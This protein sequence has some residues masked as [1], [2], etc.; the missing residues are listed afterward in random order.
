MKD[1]AALHWEHEAAARRKKLGLVKDRMKIRYHIC[2]L[3]PSD[4]PGNLLCEARGDLPGLMNQCVRS[5]DFLVFYSDSKLSWKI[6][7]QFVCESCFSIIKDRWVK[8]DCEVLEIRHDTLPHD[9][10]RWLEKNFVFTEAKN[11]GS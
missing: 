9:Y 1:D 6:E 11:V 7:G 2:H 5:P 3:T 8:S 10:R 4:V